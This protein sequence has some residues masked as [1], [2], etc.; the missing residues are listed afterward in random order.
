MELLANRVGL[1]ELPKVLICA[2]TPRSAA[3]ILPHAKAIAAALDAELTLIHVME[4]YNA[5]FVPADP[6]EWEC[7][8]REA[9]AFVSALA[10]EHSSPEC[11]ISTRVLQGCPSDQIATCVSNSLDDVVVLCRSS[12][13]TPGLLGQTVRNVLDKVEGSVLVVPP[14]AA[15]AQAPPYRSVLLPLDGSPRAEAAISVALKI[16]REQDAEIVLVHA[17][18]DPDLIAV[19]PLDTDDIELKDRLQRRNERVAQ[20]YLER[21]CEQIRS[22][23]VPARPVVLVDGDVRRQLN[24][25]ISNEPG[26]L[27][28]ISS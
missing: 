13:D 23:G 7:N 21:Q 25:A 2:E 10:N 4:A 6:V 17:V 22:L 12:A 3:K 8:R 16:A 19:G 11:S 20:D 24:G 18:P 14:T 5:N 27:V 28:V 1:G 15:D 9:E 26:S